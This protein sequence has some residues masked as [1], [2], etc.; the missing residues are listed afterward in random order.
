MKV[1]LAG[2][3]HFNPLCRPAV[4]IWLA[5]M[6]AY[7]SQAP[8]FVAVESC[9]FALHCYQ[10]QR[11]R[12]RQLAQGAW[13]R[14]SPE[15][16]DVFALSLG[17]EGDAHQS[18]I[19]DAEVLWLEAGRRYTESVHTQAEARMRL[20]GRWREAGV[21][22]G[23]ASG[24][25]AQIATMAGNLTYNDVMP[26]QPNDRPQRDRAWAEMIRRRCGGVASGWGVAIVGAMHLSSEPGYLFHFLEEAGVECEAVYLQAL[27]PPS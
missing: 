13:P 8:A 3:N 15:H 2:V 20:Y 11:P 10:E 12:Y 25:L 19:P 18:V 9:E 26:G 22:W 21:I 1:Y 17:Y 5:Q 16:L 6:L 7:L 24:L 4:E 27:L 23:P 14:L